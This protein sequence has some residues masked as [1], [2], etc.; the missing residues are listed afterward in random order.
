MAK[1]IKLDNNDNI[2]NGSAEDEK[3]LGKGGNDTLNGGKGNDN[4][5]GGDGDDTLNG[6][7]GDD[8]LNGGAGTNSVD[9]GQG[10]DTLK[11]DGNFADSV[12]TKEGSGFKIVTAGGTVTAV[13]IEKFQF[14]DQTIDLAD[15]VE[16]GQTFT[17]AIG[18]DNV[19]GTGGADLIV[20]SADGSATQTFNNGDII[21]GG[22]GDDRLRVTATP[23]AALSVLPTMTGVETVEF[24]A[25]GTADTTLNMLNSTGTTAFVSQG[26]TRSVTVD[27]QD[28]IA[29]ITLDGTSTSAS[30]MVMKYAAATVA[31]TTDVQEINLSNNGAQF[32]PAGTVNVAGVETFNVTATGVNNLTALLGDK[33]QTVTVDGSGSFKSNT[34]FGSAL[35]TFDAS[36]S[37]G[38]QSVI[39]SSGNITAKG[40]SADDFFNFQN[41]LTGADS[42]TG[43][44]G[45]DTIA[46]TGADISNAASAVLAGLNAMSG[47]ENVRFDGGNPVT[48]DL[49]TLTNTGI[50]RL[51]FNGTGADT[52]LNATSGVTYR[53]TGDNNGDVA[54]SMKAGENTLNIEMKSSTIA[55]DNAFNSADMTDLNTGTALNIKIHST[56]V[57]PSAI[58]DNDIDA[59]TNASN[60]TFTFTGDAHNE[61]DSFSNAVT[62]DASGSTGNLELGAS[63]FAD[64]IKGSSGVNTIAGLNG[65]DTI[66]LSASTAN[67]DH[68]GLRGIEDSANRDTL[69]GFKTG[70]GGDVIAI[71]N[72]DTTAANASVTFQEIAVNS[73][74]QTVLATTD[75]MEFTFNIAGTNLGDGSAASL[76][77]TNLLAAVGT[78]NVATVGAEG[79]MIAYQNGNAYLYHFDD[80]ATGTLDT[81]EIDLVATLTGVSV[82]SVSASNFEF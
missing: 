53:F 61:I 67:I 33:L 26:S 11:L 68:I 29:S 47:V 51:I 69:I 81:F 77:G 19:P 9:G 55:E 75:V 21:N 25:A 24:I 34:A 58:D 63:N 30:G 52:V 17:L 10:T 70:T 41:T 43:G 56:G 50:Q 15:M 4:I 48:V 2:F 65:V 79:Y 73:G 64:N 38:A 35:T 27:N 82:G 66:N 39:F 78:V 72:A 46:I 74:T 71:N 62:V 45:T 12:I 20:G 18:T 36:A 1:K 16:T 59:I 28:A 76:D 6:G 49:N 5:N 8:I 57:G 42:V 22:D 44:I 60:A 40:G 37:S 54:F 32:A 7:K 14:A 31:G 23:S 80:G 3:I 13:N